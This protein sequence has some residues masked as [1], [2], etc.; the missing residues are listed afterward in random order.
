MSDDLRERIDQTIEPKEIATPDEIKRPDMPATVLCGKLGE[1]CRTR[2]GDFPIAYSWLSVLAA[3][4]VL[5]KPHITHRSNI[6]VAPIGLPD[7]GK[8]EAQRRAN[9]LFALDKQ[10][11]L[12]VTDKFGSAEGMLE[13]IGDKQ[14][15]P[16]LWS[17]DELSHVLE[18][19]QIQGASF[20]F[21]L[22]TLFYNDRN[23]LTVQHRKHISFCAR[24]TIAGG[25]VEENFGNSFGAAT[26]AG[27]YSR[28]L[29]GLCPSNFRY[30]Y[31]P[32]EGA[33]IIEAQAIN[34]TLPFGGQHDTV[35]RIPQRVIPAIHPDVW[36]ARDA[37]HQQENI[38][39]R[40]L[41]LCLRV[42]IICAAWD[43]KD[44][45]R[46]SDL[47]PHW[48]LARYQQKVRQVLQP[49]PG[50]NFEAMAAHKI[51][52]YLKEHQHDDKWL[53]W[54]DVMRA[55]H[56]MEYGPSTA[57]RALDA[58]SFAGE[59]ESASIPRADGKNGRKKWVVRLAK[60]P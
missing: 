56:I 60:N 23:N 40:L 39:P 14:G 45:L 3:A 52:A 12:L 47:E 55:T 27:L 30:L 36:D 32:M 17:P 53:E 48:E 16:V 19:A 28:F 37:I 11:D 21:I 20:P 24:I 49:N 18:K 57:S 43:E 5:V 58:L 6:Y 38:E 35:A 44:V 46:A 9:Y 2:L 34:T 22:N 1:I 29:F 8:S 42:A 13:K 41:E 33:P 4:S 25:V 50:K 54:R 51:M 7:S 26:T 31:R 15:A 10:D 59:I